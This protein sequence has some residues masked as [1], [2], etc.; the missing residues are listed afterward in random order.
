MKTI[1][2]SLP[3]ALLTAL[4]LSASTSCSTPSPAGQAG[5]PEESGQSEHDTTQV[6]QEAE[7][8]LFDGLDA[9]H[10]EISTDVPAAQEYFDQG[11]VLSFGFNHAEAAR[12]FEQ[13]ARLDPTCAMCYWGK[14]LVLGPNIN[15]QMPPENVEPAWEA[16]Q[17]ARELADEHATP[18]EQAYIEALS[19]RYDADPP[20]DR[21]PLDR[22]YA[23][24]MGEV[25]EAYPEDLDAQVLYAE[26]LMDEHP[27][28]YWTDE[29]EPKPWT[30]EIMQVLE[31][32]LAE[33]PE[34]PM[35]NHLYIHAVEASDEPERALESA[36]RL[37]DMVPGAGHLVHMPSHIYIR[38][39]RYH[40]ASKANERAV[41]ADQ[42]Y[43]SQSHEAGIY[44]LGYVPHNEHFL[45][46]TTTLEGRSEDAIGAARDVQA[47][48]DP[49]MMRQPG[50]GTLQHFYSLPYYAMYTFGQWE[51]IL[52]EP[53]PADDLLYPT[54]VWHF[55]RGMAF[56]RTGRLDEAEAEL[57]EL[58]DL[59]EDERLEEVT[60][61]D[62]NT[63]ADL[64]EIGTEVLSGELA[65]ARG[66]YDEAIVHLRRGVEL[67][68]SLN[69]D[70][71]PPWG[72]S[73]RRHL[74]A[75][76]LEADKPAE[77]ERVYRA[78]LEEF[79][80][81]GWALYGLAEALDAQGKADEAAQVRE[82]LEQAWRHADVEL[83][84]SRF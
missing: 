36:K 68:D 46:A 67:E 19:E 77:A 40:E 31:D 25:A 63:T 22:A 65:A 79:P 11:L 7:V 42:Q 45:W 41:A 75:V 83:N 24:A 44:A 48:V 27:W 39:G 23:E 80:N 20:E 4:A 66:D 32:V 57:D 61:W 16:V 73:V 33:A 78:D 30:P 1:R 53:A 14:A 76:L 10:H 81:V 6:E 54:G 59:A 69:Y 3:V 17:K 28:D 35:A 64:L 38:T 37:E 52:D 2:L 34:H 51:E 72:Q 43:L 70:E 71:P 18:R 74:G 56:L 47:K 12:S 8:P 13:A 55:A 5:Q 26:A 9:H 62:I 84:A 49:D 58:A 50:M 82:R 29:G 15:L 60:L 21:S